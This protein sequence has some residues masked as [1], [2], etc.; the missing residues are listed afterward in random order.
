MHSGKIIGK[1]VLQEAKTTTIRIRT[2]CFKHE[3]TSLLSPSSKRSS[4]KV[5]DISII[6]IIFLGRFPKFKTAKERAL[7]VRKVIDS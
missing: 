3:N 7:F 5:V 2:R 6:V 1:D 4:S